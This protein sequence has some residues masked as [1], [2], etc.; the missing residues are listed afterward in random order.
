VF[1]QPAI[2]VTVTTDTQLQDD[3]SPKIEPFN[4]INLVAGDFVEVQGFE[5]DH[6]GI[7]ATEVEVKVLNDVVVQ[8]Y[9]TEATGVPSGGTMPVLGIEFSSDNSTASED[10]ND[11]T[12]LG[13][14][15]NALITAIQ[16]TP[17]LVKIQDD[18]IGD[19]I[20]DGVGDGIADEIDI[21]TP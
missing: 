17:Q 16:K 10:E 20:G 3:V 19:G 13:I 5:N 6:G 2:T 12:M 7:T 4:L 11:I 1:G 8:G 18:D 14:D 15:I 21:E 9:A